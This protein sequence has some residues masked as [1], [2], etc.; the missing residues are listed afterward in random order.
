MLRARP[1]EVHADDVLIGKYRTYAEALAATEGLLDHAKRYSIGERSGDELL[2]R[3]FGYRV[4]TTTTSD[5][6]AMGV[7]IDPRCIEWPT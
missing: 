5:L 4:G 2:N 6:A 3:G 7:P 1:F